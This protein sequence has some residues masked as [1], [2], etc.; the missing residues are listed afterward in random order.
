M[1]DK[2]T[3]GKRPIQSSS[4]IVILISYDNILAANLTIDRAAD[5]WVRRVNWTCC[6]QPAM[7]GPNM[8]SIFNSS[9]DFQS[10]GTKSLTLNR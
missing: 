2:G 1:I 9:L 6:L 4:K 7:A 5:C 3:K 10:Q 8:K